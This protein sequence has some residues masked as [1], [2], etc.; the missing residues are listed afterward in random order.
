[1]IPYNNIDVVRQHQMVATWIG[2]KEEKKLRETLQF[3]RTYN[4]PHKSS[5]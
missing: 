1:M 4:L 2:L 3:Q 5:E